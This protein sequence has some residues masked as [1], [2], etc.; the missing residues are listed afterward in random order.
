MEPPDSATRQFGEIMPVE[1][2]LSQ[3]KLQ[4]ELR[5]LNAKSLD[6][7]SKQAFIESQGTSLMLSVVL[8]AVAR[9]QVSARVLLFSCP[10]FRSS[11]FPLHFNHWRHSTS[12]PNCQ[13]T[14]ASRS[15]SSS[16]C[17]LV[18]SSYFCSLRLK[19]FASPLSSTAKARLRALC[20][21]A[22]SLG[23]RD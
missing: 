20:M 4:P 15:G 16:P 1:S 19:L 22:R 11:R 3:L 5:Q 12:F 8:K 18:K 13:S 2:L 21:S 14:S 23:G 9:A 17:N 7:P 6:S 10:T